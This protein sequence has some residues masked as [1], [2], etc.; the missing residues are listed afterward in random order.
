MA[1]PIAEIKKGTNLTS[2]LPAWYALIRY[3]IPILLI[4]VLADSVRRAY[5]AIAGLF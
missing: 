2:W 5:I 3:V 1:D 4:L